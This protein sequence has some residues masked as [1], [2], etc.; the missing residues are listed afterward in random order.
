MDDPN[1]A[2]PPPGDWGSAE[3]EAVRLEHLIFDRVH[4]LQDRMGTAHLQ[5]QTAGYDTGL[6]REIGA[7]L[8]DIMSLQHLCSDYAARHPRWARAALF[9]IRPKLTVMA[10]QASSAQ[11]TWPTHPR[12]EPPAQWAK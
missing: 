4:H 7:T 12:K 10:R 5:A 9:L 11:D 6:G 8:P 1:S 3:A 2:C